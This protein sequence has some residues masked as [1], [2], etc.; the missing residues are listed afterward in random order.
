MN[1]I[2]NDKVKQLI[3]IIQI[4]NNQKLN[5]FNDVRSLN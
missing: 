5:I 4:N 2:C 1:Y 3:S